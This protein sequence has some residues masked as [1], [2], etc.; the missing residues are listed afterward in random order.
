M[1]RPGGLTLVAVVAILLGVAQIA[2]SL[3]YFDIAGLEF[4]RESWLLGDVATVA[5]A[6]SYGIGI[7]LI[8][9]GIMGIVFAIGALGMR[10]WAWSVGLAAYLLGIA[11][12]IFMLFMTQTAAAAAATGVVSAL[13]AWYLSTDDVREAFGQETTIAGGHRPHAV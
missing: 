8:V 12:A 9:L 10:R 11:G 2:V 5:T 13:M 6:V 3:G 1:K 7:G 4:L